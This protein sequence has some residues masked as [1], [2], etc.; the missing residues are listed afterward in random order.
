M[1]SGESSMPYFFCKTRAA[2]E[3]D[4]AAAFDRVS[5]DVVVLLDYDH[6]GAALG[7]GDGCGKS[8]GAGAD[9]DDVGG[10][11]PMPFKL[12]GVGFFRA[13]AAK[14][15]SAE[16]RGRFLNKSSA[17]QCRIL[18]VAFA[19]VHMLLWANIRVSGAESA[20]ACCPGQRPGLRN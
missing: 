18:G 6:G 2:A 12:R 17:R 16:A 3:G 15:G 9:N 10:E 19:H 7:G 8:G 1:R 20:A 5:A 11:V 14:R 4:V 13:D